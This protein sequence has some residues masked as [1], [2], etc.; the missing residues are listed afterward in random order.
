MQIENDE[1]VDRAS[2]LKQKI[3]QHLSSSDYRKK[4]TDIV[5]DEPKY[6]KLEMNL[7]RLR[8]EDP[9]LADAC[10]DSPI[11]LMMICQQVLAELMKENQ[12]ADNLPQNGK[13]IRVYFDGNLGKNTVTPRGLKSRLVNKI[14]K[15]QGIVISASKVRPRLL[16][17]THF[18][19]K[20][21]SFMTYK[22]DDPM[23]LRATE[24]ED[25]NFK[26]QI[27]IYDNENNPIMM[28]FGLCDYKD[29]Q[30]LA[31]QEMP[32]NVPTGLLSRSIE[33]MLQEDLVDVAKPGDRIQVTGILRPT[34]SGQ[35]HS[36]GVFRTTIMATS[37]TPLTSIGEIMLTPQ[38]LKDINLISKNENLLPLFVRSLAPSIAGNDSIKE[39]LLLLLLGGTEKTLNNGTR[40]R[41]DINVLLVGD[42]STGKSQFL[43]R[44]MNI[45]NL[46][47]STT[48]RGSSGVGLTAAV[49]VDKDTNERQL[50]A[51]AMVLADRGII[52]IDEFDKMSIEDRVAM[53]EVMEQQT[54]TIAKAGIHVSLNARCSVLAAANPIYGEYMKNKSA[55]VNINLPDSLLSRFDLIFLLIDDR[56]SEHDRI[57]SQRVTNNHRFQGSNV[58]LQNGNDGTGIIEPLMNEEN[59][60]SVKVYEQFNP[61]LH[62]NKRTEYLSQGFMKKYI[63]H[64]K[65]KNPKLSSIASQFISA[66][67]TLLRD[68]DHSNDFK[69]RN[70]IL[71]ITIRSLES[72]IRL[73][74][75]YAK[76]RL[77]NEVDV[78]DCVNAFRIFF[79]AF[80]GGEEKFDPQFFRNIEND[81]GV[82]L[83][84]G[85]DKKPSRSSRVKKNPNIEIIIEA[86]LQL[87]DRNTE[88]E[89]SSRRRAR[90]GSSNPP[91]NST[92]KSKGNVQ[93]DNTAKHLFSILLAFYNDLKAT[94]KKNN[95]EVKTFWKHLQDNFPN[96]KY[97]DLKFESEQQYFKILEGLVN[98]SKIVID[99][100]SIFII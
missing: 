21:N 74:T 68:I 30:I 20:N 49:T 80:Y 35:T 57:V 8:Q 59:L 89:S 95:I 69:D 22:Y 58:L 25:E 73:S 86:P 37:I 32:E 3:Y 84:G 79:K 6:P 51:G 93:L 12:L 55:S 98:T 17:S 100:D 90:P 50:E 56:D 82:K 63:N 52:C 16:E 70:R 43:R 97:P 48:G 92:P 23:K 75:A 44:I 40:L 77:A 61:L 18:C 34:I 46:S 45:A 5:N 28:E 24:F 19:E 76:L 91:L 33:V 67:W 4:L 1:N 96:S 81:Y 47:F 15:V 39:A 72:I 78:Y 7:D 99:E 29:V 88:N 53:H 94:T 14:V 36:I 66:K 54:V 60:S 27:P 87:E 64:A 83:G 85:S 62:E 71:P 13:K 31:I 9:E 2:F 42:P 65:K 10:I 26:E 41:G 38:E 11:E